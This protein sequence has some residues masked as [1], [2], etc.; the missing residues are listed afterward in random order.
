ML[1]L[2]Y[3]GI[4]TSSHSIQRKPITRAM[5]LLLR[6]CT[7]RNYGCWLTILA[8]TFIYIINYISKTENDLWTLQFFLT[9]LTWWVPLK[10][11]PFKHIRFTS[12]FHLVLLTCLKTKVSQLT[13]F[14]LF[15]SVLLRSN[16]ALQSHAFCNYFMNTGYKFY[17]LHHFYIW[18]RQLIPMSNLP[19]WILVIEPCNY[20]T[21][22]RNA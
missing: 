21:V 17:T 8:K 13:L 7:P 1:Y 9:F 12:C 20:V 16:E 3:L 6:D 18:H 10:V 4:G 14:C 2:R 19:S 15:I 11:I 5:L 22:W